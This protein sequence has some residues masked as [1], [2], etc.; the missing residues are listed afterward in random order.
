MYP[1]EQKIKS[2]GK[3]IAFVLFMLLLSS[4]F[5]PETVMILLL[6]LIY[7]KMRD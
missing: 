7:T 5:K 1:S 2:T 3:T 4:Y 6:C